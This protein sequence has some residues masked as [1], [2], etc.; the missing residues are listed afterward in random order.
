MGAY[1][2]TDYDQLQAEQL[3]Q[4]QQIFVTYWCTLPE[5]EILIYLSEIILQMDHVKKYQTAD[6]SNYRF[7]DLN[8]Y[9]DEIYKIMAFLSEKRK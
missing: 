2:L 4:Q 9:K 3:Q 1:M 6:N 7:Y 8:I 5:D